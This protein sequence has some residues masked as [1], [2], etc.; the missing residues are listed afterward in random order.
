MIR[1]KNLWILKSQRA[2]FHSGFH[3][4]IFELLAHTIEEY[5]YKGL[6]IFL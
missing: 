3:F 2:L 6:K 4:G 5:Y 1:T